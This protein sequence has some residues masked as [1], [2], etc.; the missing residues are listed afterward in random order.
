L[1]VAAS[2]Q[3]ASRGT[4]PWWNE[5]SAKQAILDF[6]RDT[7]ARENPKFVPTEE[8]IATFDQDGTLWVE[9]PI[10][11]Q[12]V[13]CLDRVQVLATQ[14]PELKEVKP[15][16][17]VL[18][19]NRE[20][21]AELSMRVVEATKEFEDNWVKHHDETAAATLVVKTDSWYMGSNVGG[22][23]RRLL[24]YIGGVGNYNRQCDE[25]AANG[26]QGFALT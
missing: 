14:K 13:Y 10:Y 24:A 25:L 9:H 2:A 4:L 5:G 6:V 19:G 7:T 12:M 16:K 1:S 11:S 18:A 8:R 21:I 23:P 3:T 15:F 17:T 26:Y 20:A 22:K